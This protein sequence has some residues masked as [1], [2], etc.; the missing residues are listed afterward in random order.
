MPDIQLQDYTA[1][2][3]DLIQ[4]GRLDEAIAHGQHILRQHPKH[5]ET[6]C[7]LGEA[8]LEKGM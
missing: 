2:L 6:Y 7:I 5:V 3:K 8:C 1:K 4:S